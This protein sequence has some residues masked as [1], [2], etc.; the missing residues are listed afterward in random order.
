MHASAIWLCPQDSPLCT[1]PHT[2][3]VCRKQLCAPFPPAHPCLHPARALTAYLYT[4]HL[5]TSLPSFLSFMPLTRAFFFFFTS[6]LDLCMC[7][8]SGPVCLQSQIT[9]LSSS[10]ARPLRA[11]EACTLRP[12]LREMPMPPRE[13]HLRKGPGSGQRLSTVK[14]RA[15]ACLLHACRCTNKHL[16]LVL[17]NALHTS[18]KLGC[19]HYY[20]PALSMCACM[21]ALAKGLGNN[22]LRMQT[23]PA[24]EH[25]QKMDLESQKGAPHPHPHPH[26]SSTQHRPGMLCFCPT[27]GFTL[28]VSC[29]NPPPW[30]RTMLP[31]VLL[32]VCPVCLHGLHVREEE[33]ETNSRWLGLGNFPPPPKCSTVRWQ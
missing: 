15:L 12:P 32:F 10:V 25:Q 18:L 9:N 24:K 16:T 27:P 26:P 21:H 1:P 29:P 6:L 28:L 23:A 11:L 13:M 8:T 30:T 33:R 20:T 7:R 14:G 3:R 22:T 2:E 19:T 4:Y 5:R 17:F 31:S